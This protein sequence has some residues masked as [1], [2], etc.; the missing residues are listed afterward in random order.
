MKDLRALYERTKNSDDDAR[1]AWKEF[2]KNAYIMWGII[3]AQEA[4]IKELEEA[5]AV[6][7]QKLGDRCCACSVDKITDICDVHQPIVMQ[8]EA[9]IKRLKEALEEA[10]RHIKQQTEWLEHIYPQI[11]CSHSIQM[12]FSSAAIDGTEILECIKSVLNKR[13]GNGGKEILLRS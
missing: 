2:P 1:E 12:G 5:N 8:Q 7:M 9:D 10:E 13:M 6:M 11:K 3:E 4:K